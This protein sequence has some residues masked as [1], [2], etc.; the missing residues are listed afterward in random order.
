[1]KIFSASGVEI[2]DVI[3]EDNSYR[4]RA[5]MGEHSL[6]LYYSLPEH[7]EIPIGSYCDF[8][9]ERFTLNRPE[10]IKKHHTRDFAY[11]LILDSGKSNVAQYKFR[12]TE[13][14]LKFSL[15]AKPI[16]HLRMVVDNLNR[17]E[18]GWVV[19]ACIDAVE[20][21]IS[22]NH[23]SCLDV[24]GQLSSEFETEYEVVGKVISLRKVEYNKGAPLALSYGKGNGFKSGVGR[25][26]DGDKPP[27][28]I[29]FVQGGEK[30]IDFSK[31]GSRDLLL[32][33]E[34][35]FVYDGKEY[36]TDSDGLSLR[37]KN[38]QNSFNEG[39]LDLSHLSITNRH[40]FDSYS[41]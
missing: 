41:H 14:R 26:N 17:R 13:G 37:R 4:Y 2:L 24:L 33:I 35:T 31:Y 19:G 16:D 25:V 22:Y 1:M 9:G 32:P 3:V 15:T 7:V 20:K 40:S 8:Q 30:N 5:I 39:S 27:V 12:D 18:S 38:N 29:L 34:Q 11:T 10:N 21:T 36:V 28:D 6:T 23:A